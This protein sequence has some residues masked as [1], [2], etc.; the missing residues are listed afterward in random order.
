MS[1]GVTYEQAAAILGCHISDVAKLIAKGQLTSRGNVRDGSLSREQ[2]ET[3]AK[4]RAQEREARAARPR[5]TKKSVDH[6][7]GTEHE[8]LTPDRLRSS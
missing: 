7:P 6:R 5:R 4:R 1:D 3:L 2:V 8:W